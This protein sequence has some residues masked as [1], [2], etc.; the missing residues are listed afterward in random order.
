MYPELCV[1]QVPLQK[2][3]E[4]IP[5]KATRGSSRHFHTRAVTGCLPIGCV[6]LPLDS[7]WPVQNHLR[8]VI[9]GP[10]R[11]PST[12]MPGEL[13][14]TWEAGVFITSLFFF[15]NIK[16]CTWLNELINIYVHTTDKILS[17]VKSSQLHAVPFSDSQF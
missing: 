14:M 17:S 5:S 7:D 6:E 13:I 4:E 2:H 15:F 8:L 16:H 9:V 10:S 11:L 3:M 1:K 12:R